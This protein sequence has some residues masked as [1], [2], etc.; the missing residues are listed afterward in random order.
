MTC[1]AKTKR[2]A[3]LPPEIQLIWMW[4]RGCGDRNTT[5]IEAAF[6]TIGKV[7]QK[8]PSVCQQEG[9]QHFLVDVCIDWTSA[10]QWTDV[11]R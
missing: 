10:N 9:I 3:A 5:V 2:S 6:D 11:D 7:P 1:K 8:I 4:W